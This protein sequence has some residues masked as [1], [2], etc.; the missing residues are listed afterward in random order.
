MVLARVQSVK[1]GFWDYPVA[2]SYLKHS[3]GLIFTKLT[4]QNKNLDT[5]YREPVPLCAI[6]IHTAYIVATGKITKL[7]TFYP[8]PVQNCPIGT[9]VQYH[10]SENSLTAFWQSANSV[11]SENTKQEVI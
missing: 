5:F 2:M 1:I 7:D 3:M 4:E 6:L 8:E 11:N 9:Q 10:I